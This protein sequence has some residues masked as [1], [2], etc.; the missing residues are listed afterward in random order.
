[1]L[2]YI[3]LHFLTVSCVQVKISSVPF[4][5]SNFFGQL[6]FF[7]IC[8]TDFFEKPPFTQMCCNN[9][10][11]MRVVGGDK[12]VQKPK[13]FVDLLFGK[14]GVVADVFYFKSVHVTAFS[15]HNVWQGVEAWVAYW[16]PDGVEAFFLQKL[17]QYCFAVEAS[18]S[19]ATKFYSVYFCGQRFFPLVVCYFIGLWR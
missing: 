1:M 12:L 6:I 17:N 10:M 4:E 14:V 5:N 13:E 16:N 15:C 19:P 8:P 18:F 3:P 2:R 11:L 9:G 7:P